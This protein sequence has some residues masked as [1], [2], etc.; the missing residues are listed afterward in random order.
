VIVSRYLVEPVLRLFDDEDHEYVL[1]WRLWTMRW[2]PY[3][4]AEWLGWDEENDE[5][6]LG[7][8]RWNAPDVWRNRGR[9]R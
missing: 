7:P 5:M 4:T 8:W 1:R 3:R 6:V 9:S 2:F